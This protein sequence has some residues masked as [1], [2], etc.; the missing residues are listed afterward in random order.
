ME[1]ERTNRIAKNT[2]ILYVQ[3]LLGLFV[4]LYTS[5]VILNVLGVEDFGIYNVVGGVVVMFSVL[6][7]AMSSSSSR[8]LTFALG[9]KNQVQLKK[10]FGSSVFIHTG[11]GLLVLLIA[12]LLGVWFMTAYMNIPTERMH[13]ATWVFHT[14]VMSLFL[15]IACVP[16]RSVIIAHE[17]FI[18]LALISVTELVLRLGVV[19]LLLVSTADKLIVYAFLTLFVQI[20]LSLTYVLYCRKYFSETRGTLVWNRSL[21]K[22]MFSFA[23][24]SLFG[25]S[26][27][28]LMTQGVNVLL[29]IFFGAS[30][31]AGRGIAVQ[32]QGVISRFISSFQ[33]AV[34]PQLT[35]SYANNDLIFMHRLIYSSSKFS[36]CLFLLLAMPVFLDTQH[37]LVLWLKIVPD[38]TVNFIRLLMLISLVDCLANPL[39][40]AAKATGTIR[41]YQS[42]LGTLLLFVVPISYFLLKLGYAPEVVFVTHLFVVILGQIVRVILIKPMIH[43]SYKDYF[44]K[45]FVKCLVVAIFA[46]IL[47]VLLAMNL[48]ASLLRLFLIAGA[49]VVSVSLLLYFFGLEEYEKKMIGER[50]FERLNRSIV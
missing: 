12:E 1:L 18:A 47:P 43:L 38:H 8:F 11:L 32:V 9:K 22:E 46:P 14:T 28:M 45:V 48:D 39:I 37:V 19:F 21:F 26:A 10:V 40:T 24:W 29:N 44:F 20:I 36:F 23:G 50:F 2:I 49:S 7:N 27:V 25:D 42:I 17:K 16:F 33:A 31:N 35:K 4:G 15:T 5:R 41:R 6:N 3:M 13:A 34:N 30:V